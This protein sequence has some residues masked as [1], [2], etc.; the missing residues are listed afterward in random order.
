MNSQL[1]K[2]ARELPLAEQIKLID[3]LWESIAKQGY[4]PPLT[5][6]Q[7]AELDRRF[8]AH[9]RQPDD[10][11]SWDSIKQEISEKYSHR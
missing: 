1:V 2:D 6:E 9:R 7:A 4:E 11:V 5:P 10:V 8:D 3:A